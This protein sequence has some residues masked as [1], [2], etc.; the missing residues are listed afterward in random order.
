MIGKGERGGV[1][2]VQEFDTV[3][4]PSP[5]RSPRIIRGERE[6]EGLFIGHERGWKLRG[7]TNRDP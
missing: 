3:D 2:E 1:L 7:G 5:S 4:F 6:E